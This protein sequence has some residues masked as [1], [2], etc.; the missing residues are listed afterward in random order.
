MN[1]KKIHTMIG[2]M[3]TLLCFMFAGP[4][5]ADIASPEEALYKA[6]NV[7]MLT[8]RILKNY[9]L[10]GQGI[11]ARK[12]KSE[13]S[14]NIDTFEAQLT[15]LKAYAEDDTSR[16]NLRAVSTLWEKIKPELTA[17]PEKN[18]VEAIREQSEALLQNTAQVIASLNEFSHP[19]N[20][21]LIDLTGRQAMLSQRIAGTYALMAWGYEEKYRQ[22][23]ESSYTDFIKTMELIEGV[24]PT[25]ID[26]PKSDAALKKI[27]RQFKRVKPANGDTFV[28]SLVDR[29]SEKLLNSINT[30]TSLYAGLK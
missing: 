20:G 15:E 29:S 1:N 14:A 28:P 7:R 26:V 23:Y 18:K 9:T 25:N 16:T 30:I 21:F 10:V 19:T 6:S 17:A 22:S 5:K 12:A 3:L 11:R 8:Q 13:L 4:A 27:K 24:D 2:P